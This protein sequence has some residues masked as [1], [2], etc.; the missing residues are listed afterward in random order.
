MSNNAK[1]SQEVTTSSQKHSN[2]VAE[3]RHKQPGLVKAEP[4]NSK[5][6]GNSRNVKSAPRGGS[7]KAKGGINNNSTNAELQNKRSSS[8]KDRKQKPSPL[9]TQKVSNKG[10]IGI[11]SYMP[12]KTKSSKSSN[13]KQ[14]QA[15]NTG[16]VRPTQP[17]PNSTTY[18]EPIQ[19]HANLLQAHNLSLNNFKTE[20]RLPNPQKFLHEPQFVKSPF[21]SKTLKGMMQG[22]KPNTKGANGSSHAANY[23][24]IGNAFQTN[25][26]R[27]REP[28]GHSSK[29]KREASS[30]HK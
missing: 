7:E 10:G 17:H 19:Q 12:V 30:S 4:Y 3:N 21:L 16:T 2:L 8:Y 14:F 1:A 15:L 24:R 28:S 5:M 11:S 20:I 27:R 25:G 23:G 29:S 22:S 13:M 18:K 6:A 9:R 26:N